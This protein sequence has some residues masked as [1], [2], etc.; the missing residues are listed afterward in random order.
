MIDIVI[1]KGPTAVG[2]T[3]LSI[4]LCDEFQAELLCID[5]VQV[6]RH[7]NIGSAKPSPQLQE[8]YPHHLINLFDPDEDCDAARWLAHADKAVA[9][10][11]ERGN[12]AVFVGGTNLYIR[13]LTEGLFDAPPRDEEIR[14][15]HR[16]RALAHGT[17][18][19]H[20]ELER[21]DPALATR[22]HPKDLIRISRGLEI[23]EQTGRKLS[24][25]QQEH[26]AKPPRYNALEIELTRPRDELYE[27]INTRVD[28]MLEQGLIDE[29][30][31]I[32][33]ELGYDPG[34]KSLQTL[35]YRHVGEQLRGE[36]DL[37]EMIRLLKRDTRRFAKAQLSWLRQTQGG[38]RLRADDM[39]GARSL[40][41]SALDS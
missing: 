41:E 14:A 5:S 35:G 16:Q 17:E 18:S 32:T 20:E 30:R 2:K 38:H 11:Q 34:L 23:W 24:E 36:Y 19:L 10:V 31:H 28:G 9:E 29:Y 1:I 3:D 13:A 15:R 6:Y 4:L 26:Q 27:R 25:L 12:L 8:R 39:D 22:V 40:I 21:I 33:E 7:L 37:A